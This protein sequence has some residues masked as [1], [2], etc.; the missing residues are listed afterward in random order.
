[1]LVENARSRAVIVGL[2]GLLE[3]RCYKL[4][5]RVAVRRVSLLI[6]L[7]C[8]AALAQQK[9]EPA[10]EP[11]EEDE[12]LIQQEYAFNP[13]QAEKEFKVGEFYRK[14]K[15]WK[16]AAGRYSEATKWNPGFAEAWFKLGEAHE[17]L[18]DIAAAREAYAKF[19]ELSPQ[20]K[21]AAGIRKKLAGAAP[22]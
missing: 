7:S 6:V 2:S 9:Q 17:N 21:R 10:Q 3:H 20:D 15:S 13:L 14:R 11:P 16:A 19:L 18:K 22:H 8:L 5:G 12:S 1:V 4:L